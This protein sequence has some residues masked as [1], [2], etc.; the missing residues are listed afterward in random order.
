MVPPN[1]FPRLG[2]N[3]HA[4]FESKLITGKGFGRLMLIQEK[5]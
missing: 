2:G 4:M 1:A 3:E 5:L